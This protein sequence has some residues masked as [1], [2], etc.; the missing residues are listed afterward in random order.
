MPVRI[1]SPAKEYFPAFQGRPAITKLDL[2][3]FYLDVGEAVLTGLHER[4]TGPEPGWAGTASVIAIGGRP[5]SR[6]LSAA[7]PSVQDGRVGVR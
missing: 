5:G 1:S 3:E 2:V 4:P 7:V 6:R